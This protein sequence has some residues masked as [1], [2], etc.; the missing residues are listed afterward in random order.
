MTERE[1]MQWMLNAPPEMRARIEMLANGDTSAAQNPI[2]DARTCSQSAAA[3]L[4]GVSRQTIVRMMK[5]NQ[6]GTVVICGA[7]RILL[8]SIDAI[9][10]GNAMTRPEIKAELA[11]RRERRAESGRKGAAARCRTTAKGGAQ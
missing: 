3:R 11:E 4:L 6:I 5:R 9:S 1:L 8:S 2:G 7:P 10:R